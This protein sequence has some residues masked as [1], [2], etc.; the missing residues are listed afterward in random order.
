M[1]RFVGPSMNSKGD[2]MTQGEY[3][4]KNKSIN[5]DEERLHLEQEL[6]RVQQDLSLIE[7]KLLNKG[8]F[9]LGQGAPVVYEWEMN[10]SLKDTALEKIKSIQTALERLQA[11]GYGLCRNC[12]QPIDPERLEV[13][14]HTTLCVDCAKA[15]K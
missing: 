13:L 15:N 8:E 14:P 10:L 2:V 3:L 7:E 9:G 4:D 6:A 12:G 1:T 11:G 5:L